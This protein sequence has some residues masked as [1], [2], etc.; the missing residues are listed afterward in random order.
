MLYN[1][2]QNGDCLYYKNIYYKIYIYIYIYAYSIRYY[3]C[4][5]M[6]VVETIQALLNVHGGALPCNV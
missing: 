4:I 3:Y 6:I 5:F 2:K 1:N